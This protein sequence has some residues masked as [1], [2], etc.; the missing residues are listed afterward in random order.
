MSGTGIGWEWNRAYHDEAAARRGPEEEA[1]LAALKAKPDRSA[2][3]EQELRVLTWHPDFADRARAR[4]LAAAEDRPFPINRDANAALVAELRAVPEAEL[5]RR[6]RTLQVPV[7]VVHGAEDPRPV[8]AP[9]TMVQA[10]PDARVEIV[11]GAGHLPWVDAPARTATVLR[12]FAA[13]LRRP[14]SQ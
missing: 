10:L 13:D 1:R 11:P 6:C 7:L 2:E 8:W 5:A 9:D 3:E 14:Q 12:A 4:E